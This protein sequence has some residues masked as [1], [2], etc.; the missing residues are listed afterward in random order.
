MATNQRFMPGDRINV[1]VPEGTVSGDPV[2]IGSLP[3]V[4]VT[5]RD[6]DGNA[7]VWF[8]G[9]WDLDVTGAVTT[10]GAP[11]YLASSGLNAANSGSDTLFGYALATKT[12]AESTIPVKIARA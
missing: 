9:V 8:D 11:V 7:T 12:A 10:I 1:P 5:S 2:V 4:A 3:G 6:T